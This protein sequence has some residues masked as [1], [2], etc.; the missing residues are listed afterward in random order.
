MTRVV[1]PLDDFIID[2]LII[3]TNE[4]WFDSQYTED[5]QDE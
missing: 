4:E 5:E 2:N 1:Q 3:P